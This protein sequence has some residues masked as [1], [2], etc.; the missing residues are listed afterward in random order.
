MMFNEF[1]QRFHEIYGD[2]FDY[3]WDEDLQQVTLLFCKSLGLTLEMIRLDF[4]EDSYSLYK[5]FLYEEAYD[6]FTALRV[7]KAALLF[8]ESIKNT[9]GQTAEVSYDCG[10]G[11]PFNS[12]LIGYFRRPFSWEDL[13]CMLN[14]LIK[15]YQCFRKID[16]FKTD[17]QEI[18]KTSELFLACKDTQ[19]EIFEKLQRC[20]N[21]LGYV[22]VE[23]STC[24]SNRYFNGVYALT[25]KSQTILVGVG[26][27]L[28]PS[29]CR[30]PQPCSYSKFY[31]ARYFIV[32]SK[33]DTPRVAVVGNYLYKT[34]IELVEQFD[35]G[36]EWDFENSF[37]HAI[38]KDGKLVVWFEEFWAIITCIK[39][40][41]YEECFTYE[42]NI[43][44]KQQNDFIS[45]SSEKFWNQT[46]Q[47]TK[48]DDEQFEQ[49]CKDLLYSL[50][51]DNISLRGKSRAPDGGI[52]IT[53]DEEYKTLIG[54]E[55]RKWIFQCKHMKG[56]IGRKD[57]SEVRDLLSEFSADCYGLFYS[58]DLTPNTID[59]ITNMRENLGLKI[60]YWDHSRLE[61]LLEK[62]PRI[63]TKYF[64]I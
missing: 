54:T 17:F 27:E 55:K 31:G 40:E 4:S 38:S 13:D 3:D 22:K 6:L 61:V 47:F 29:F 7:Q 12:Q 32:S 57:L 30:M 62:Y 36:Q 60:E 39:S 16:I 9:T 11:C 26:L 49:L 34:I 28:L 64:G 14:G 53:A 52:D 45:V 23:A 43:I 56:Q 37:F 15:S 5:E 44:K 63:A 33:E 58:G 20:L 21:P 59:R 25:N 35:K 24:N 50:G 8:Y 41:M 51:F 48:L 19:A 10:Y 18:D 46:Y 42:K 1:M 2:K